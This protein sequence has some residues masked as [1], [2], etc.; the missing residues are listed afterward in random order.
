MQ[1]IYATATERDYE[2]EREKLKH[3]GNFFLHLFKFSTFQHITC[4]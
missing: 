3:L 1:I 4:Y 2:S